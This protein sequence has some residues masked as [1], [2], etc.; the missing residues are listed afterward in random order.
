MNSSAETVITFGCCW[1]RYGIFERS[2]V[3]GESQR[4]TQGFE[5]AEELKLA[6]GI[7]FL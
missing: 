7:S 1:S 2:Q 5:I 6:G 4:V 3:A